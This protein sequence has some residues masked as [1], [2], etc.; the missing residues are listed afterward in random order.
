MENIKY[1]DNISINSQPLP[2]IILPSTE[3]DII[4]TL[5]KW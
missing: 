1:N 2:K 3:N 5:L 4:S